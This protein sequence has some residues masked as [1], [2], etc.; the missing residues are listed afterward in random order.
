MKYFINLK[1]FSTGDNQNNELRITL[2]FQKVN[3]VSKYSTYWLEVYDGQTEKNPLIANYTFENGK[4]PE[5]IFSRSS[6]M[7]VKLKFQCNYPT[8][9]TLQPLEIQRLQQKNKWDQIQTQQLLYEEKLYK[10]NRPQSPELKADRPWQENP[11][12]RIPGPLPL[13]QL[14]LQEQKE[15]WN[16]F[17]RQQQI[18][19]SKF[20]QELNQKQHELKQA[21]IFCPY[22]N[23]DDITMYAMIGNLKNPDLVIKNSVFSRNSINGINATGLHSLVQINETTIANNQMNGIHV[24]GGAGDLSL[25]HCKVESNSMNGIY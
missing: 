13:D 23:Y 3:I 21:R 19:D 18:Q 11:D 12:R 8:D 7:F 2:H 9:R 25:Y 24:Q 14:T 10:Y 20:K 1:T 5:S 6:Y 22:S 16:I 17:E 4:T 15:Q